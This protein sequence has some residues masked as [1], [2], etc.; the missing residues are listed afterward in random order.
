MY[1]LAWPFMLD[2]KEGREDAKRK[3]EVVFEKNMSSLGPYR[4]S[5]IRGSSSNSGF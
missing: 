2:W 1:R 4:E 3:F 5:P